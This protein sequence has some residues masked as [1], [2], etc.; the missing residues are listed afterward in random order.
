MTTPC[1]NLCE[2]FF[3]LSLIAAVGETPLDFFGEAGLEEDDDDGV[4]ALFIPFFV[5]PSVDV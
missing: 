4:D 1:D 2:A 3:S 5:I